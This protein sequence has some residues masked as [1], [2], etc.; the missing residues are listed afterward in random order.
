MLAQVY[1]SVHVCVGLPL[2]CSCPPGARYC[3]R[4]C[5]SQ[6]W[7]LH[8]GE[9]GTLPGTPGPGSTDGASSASSTPVPSA[10][11]G[12][13]AG[14]GKAGDAPSTKPPVGPAGSTG[15]PAPGASSKA[16][17]K[18]SVSLFHANLCAWCLV[19]GRVGGMWGGGGKGGGVRGVGAANLVC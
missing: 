8:K 10:G 6:R 15:G 1:I 13:G 3:S 2:C 14:A 9:C 5:Q 17:A 18:A 11:G 7:P 4:A 19:R 16:S 12:G